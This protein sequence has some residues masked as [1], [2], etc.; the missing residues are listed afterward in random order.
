M[1]ERK[2]I[3]THPELESHAPA[4]PHGLQIYTKPYMQEMILMWW[5]IFF[6]T[7][8]VVLYIFLRRIYDVH[9]AS[10]LQKRKRE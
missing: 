7:S 3:I 5:I 4:E 10:R 1:E 8:A 2:Y 6:S 9:F